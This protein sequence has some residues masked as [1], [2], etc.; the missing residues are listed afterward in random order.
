MDLGLAGRTAVV[1]GSSGGLGRACATALLEAGA[2]GGVHGRRADVLETAL[3]ELKASTGGEVRAVAA[4][5]TTEDG[6]AALLGACPDPDILVNNS[7]GPPPGSFE[8]WG[9]AE[10]MAA[11]QANMVWPILLT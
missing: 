6:R 2:A 5:V 3:A 4:D 10:W 11:L 8:D 7:A 1:C 9:E